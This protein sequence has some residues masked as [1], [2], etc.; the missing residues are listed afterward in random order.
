LIIAIMGSPHI[1]FG[2]GGIG[3]TA[4]SFT[5][6]WDTP[7]SVSELLAKLTAL[8]VTQL[9]SAASYPPSNAWNTETLLGQAS[10]IDKGF[11]I[12]SKIAFHEGSKLNDQTI[13][14]SLDKTLTLLGAR[15]VHIL[16]S[17][18]PDPQTPVA[19]TAA[20]YHRQYVAGKFERVCNCR[21]RGQPLT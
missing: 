3:T 15:K 7:E 17:H 6:T 11:V 20:A 19:E 18:I 2:A 10:A 13:S 21:L 12:D 14:A 16:Y 1:V 5:F 4:N 9:D 8:G